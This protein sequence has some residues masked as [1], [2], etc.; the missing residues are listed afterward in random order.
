MTITIRKPNYADL[1]YIAFLWADEKTMEDVGGIHILKKEDY[2]GFLKKN[3]D[4]VDNSRKYFLIC[5]DEAPIGEVSF[6]NYDKRTKTAMLNIKI[7]Y[8]K[9]RKKYAKEALRLFCDYY[10][11][12]F[13]GEILEDLVGSPSGKAFLHKIEYPY[14]NV[15]SKDDLSICMQNVINQYNIPIS[16]ISGGVAVYFQLSKHDYEQGVLKIK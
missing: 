4:P 2:D 1:D 6:S 7:E 13:G 11:H 15:E 9:R 8:A 3:V 10:F 16:E 5:V 12:D 14:I